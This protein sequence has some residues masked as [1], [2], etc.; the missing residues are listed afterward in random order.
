MLITVIILHELSHAFIKFWFNGI[1]TNVGVG[2]GRDPQDGEAGW[3]V[4][5]QIMGGRLAVEWDEKVRD[6]DAINRVLLIKPLCTLEIGE[7]INLSHWYGTNLPLKM[8]RHHE[9]FFPHF[10]RPQL[11]SPHK[12]E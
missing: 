9:L 1:I 8:R 3:L 7:R 5:E 11:I 2:A 10:E 12:I 4:E 6:M